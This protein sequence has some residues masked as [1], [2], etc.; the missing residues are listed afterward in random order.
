MNTQ[1]LSQV[2]HKSYRSFAANGMIA[3]LALCGLLAVLYFGPRHARNWKEVREIDILDVEALG[4]ASR[5]SSVLVTGVLDGNPTRTLDGLVAYVEQRR[6][7]P[8]GVGVHY[9]E[10]WTTVAQVFPPLSLQV[11]GQHFQVAQVDSIEWGGDLHV[12]ALPPDSAKAVN[13]IAKEAVQVMGFKDGDQVTVIGLKGSDGSLIPTGMYG[14]DRASLLR[15]L[16]K[17]A[18]VA[19]A[20]GLAFILALWILFLACHGASGGETILRVQG[21]SVK[22]ELRMPSSRSLCRLLRH[23]VDPESTCCACPA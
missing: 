8:N 14:G 1:R 15:E 18:L 12:L 11:D 13:G 22:V 19:Y 23:P 9:R 20:S 2:V 3:A 17:D 5:H 21:H 4:A 16:G 7:T 6:D 10:T